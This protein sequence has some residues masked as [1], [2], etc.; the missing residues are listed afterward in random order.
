MLRRSS[1]PIIERLLLHLADQLRRLGSFPQAGVAVLLRAADPPALPRQLVR[2]AYHQHGELRLPA[3]LR[4]VVDIGEHLAQL[5]HL[6]TREMMAEQLEDLGVADRLPGLRRGNQDRPHFRG[7]GKQP[8]LAHR[9]WASKSTGVSSN[10]SSFESPCGQGITSRQRNVPIRS[11]TPAMLRLGSS[12]YASGWSSSAS[13]RLPRKI[14]RLGS[15]SSHKRPAGRWLPVCLTMVSWS[16]S[17]S[18]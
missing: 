17:T 1:R 3:L 7:V 2:L 6:R 12:P 16:P 13:A 8:R 10:T 5:A 14:M 9:G 18:T 11:N 15:S 4:L